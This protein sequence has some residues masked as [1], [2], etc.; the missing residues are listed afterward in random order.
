[1]MKPLVEIEFHLSLGS[2]RSELLSDNEDELRFALSP[3]SYSLIRDGFHKSFEQIPEFQV[4][5]SHRII[6]LLINSADYLINTYLVKS[7]SFCSLTSLVVLLH[8][9]ESNHVKIL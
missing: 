3:Q 2:S 1:M 9:R 6:E 8:P 4:V 7:I 5:A